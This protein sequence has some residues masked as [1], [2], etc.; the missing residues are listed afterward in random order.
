VGAQVRSQV[1]VQAET[2]AAYFALIRLLTSMY[3]LMSFQFAVVK[4]LFTTAFLRTSVESFAMGH[5]VLSVS[6]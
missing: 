4:E 6:N 2:L 5:Q 1:E 3:E